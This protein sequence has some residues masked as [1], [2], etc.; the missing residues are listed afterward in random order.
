M[1]GV[2]AAPAS[3]AQPAA[4]SADPTMVALFD[5]VRARSSA[6]VAPPPGPVTTPSGY[7]SFTGTARRSIGVDTHEPEGVIG[8]PATTSDRLLTSILQR[9]GWA[10]CARIKFS[11]DDLRESQQSEIVRIPQVA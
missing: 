7:V 8:E 2:T 3:S 9:T 5:I 6:S 11:W 1:S 4:A 10:E